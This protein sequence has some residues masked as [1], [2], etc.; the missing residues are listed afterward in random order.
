MIPIVALLI[1]IYVLNLIDY[2]Q[3]AY[4]ISLFGIGVELNPIGRW[5]FSI[6]CAWVPKIIIVPMLLVIMGLIIWKYR[7]LS[8]E[9]YLLLIFYILVVINNFNIML[10][11]GAI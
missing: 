6:G 4:T 1:I 9:I 5:L 3:T 7:E 10:E 11:L 8:W 2:F